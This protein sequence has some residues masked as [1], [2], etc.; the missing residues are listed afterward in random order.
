MRLDCGW[1]SIQGATAEA[2]RR[3]ISLEASQTKRIWRRLGYN[4]MATRCVGVEMARPASL[5]SLRLRNASRLDVK[6]NAHHGAAYKNKAID[7]LCYGEMGHV[8][9]LRQ[10]RSAYFD[11][12]MRR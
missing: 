5:T 12:N 10:Y 9:S 8:F 2:G 11:I 6:I 1:Y 3:R 7:K 4:R